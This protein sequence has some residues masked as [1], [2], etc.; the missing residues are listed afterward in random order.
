MY[1]IIKR[2]KTN[3]IKYVSFISSNSVQLIQYCMEPLQGMQLE[4]RQRAESPYG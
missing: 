1:I 2:N 3:Y 4:S